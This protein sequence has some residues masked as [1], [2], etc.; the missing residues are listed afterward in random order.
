M[1]LGI[2]PFSELSFLEWQLL[3]C[4]H[5]FFMKMKAYFRLHNTP[6]KHADQLSGQYPDLANP[7]HNLHFG[8]NNG[9]SLLNVLKLLTT[10]IHVRVHSPSK[11]G[12]ELIASDAK[13]RYLESLY[14]WLR[15][16]V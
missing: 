12:V 8:K 9:K 4:L 5:R 16:I 14:H 11:L 10:Q 1:R 15:C 3:N 2:I 7:I 6:G 13:Y